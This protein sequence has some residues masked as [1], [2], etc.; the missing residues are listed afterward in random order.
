MEHCDIT[1][2]ASVEPDKPSSQMRLNALE[3]DLQDREM[4]LEKGEWV[5]KNGQGGQNTFFSI[6]CIYVTLC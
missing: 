4:T 5:P 1:I 2:I 3:A 6:G